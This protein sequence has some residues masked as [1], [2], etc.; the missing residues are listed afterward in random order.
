MTPIEQRIYNVGIIPVIKIEDVKNAV[1]LA[2]ALIEG[3]LP[4][5]EVTFRTSCASEAIAAMK[6]AFPD[7]LIGAGTVLT[8]EQADQAAAAGASFIVSPGLNPRVVSHC[9]EKGLPIIPGCANPSDIECALELGLETV[10]FFPA[11]TAGGL[12]MLKAMSAPYG[13]L[14]FM[15]T[16]GIDATNVL[17]YLKFNKIIA[18][19]GSFMVKDSLIKAGD[20]A[21][22]TALTRE[23]V[24][25]M[26]GLEFLHL[27]MNNETEEEARKGA[28]LLS[29]LF[30][31]TL[32]EGEKG[33]FVGESFEVMKSMGRGT[34]GHVA[35][36][37]NFLDRAVAY[38]ERMGVEFDKSTV[39]YFDDGRPKFIYFKDEICGF[40]VHLIEK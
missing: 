38:F 16:G 4:A 18:C 25:T 29:A 34:K 3:G 23:A 30:G 12:P 11:E 40:A 28:A 13:K 19:G 32:N 10:K 15:P 22:I 37:T 5:A 33:I 7:M 6:N 8:P 39:T 20:F 1:P 24:R 36:R 26:L 21:A 27:G 14:R 2:R 17:S 31:G 9:K 35:I